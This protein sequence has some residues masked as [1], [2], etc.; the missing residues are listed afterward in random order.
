MEIF[1]SIIIGAGQAG[2]AM[3]AGLRMR[4][5][6]HVVLERGRVAQRWRTERWDSFRLLSPNWQTRLPGHHYRDGD[7]DGF[8]TGRQVIALLERYAASAPVRTGVNVSGVTCADRGYQVVTTAG[9]LWCRNVVVATG[10][11][12]RPRIPAISAEL[13]AEVVQLHSSDYRNPAQLPPGAVLVVGAGPSGQQIADELARAGRDVHIAAGRHHM[14]P[15]RYRGQ[16]SYWWM[17]RMGTLSRTVE[18]LSDPDERFALNA[19]LAGGTA[20][21]DLHRLVRAGVRPHG[22]LIGYA[23]TSLIFAA[24]LAQTLTDAEAAAARFR[25]SVDHYVHRTGADA[26]VD[27]AVPPAATWLH[28]EA[29]SLDVRAEKLGAVIWATG[30]TTDRSWLPKT[31]LSASGELRQTRGVSA[32]PGL[33]FLGLKW[34][35]RRSSHTI[36]GVGRDAEYLAEHIVTRFAQRAAQTGTE[37][38]IQRE[39]ALHRTVRRAGPTVPTRESV[40]HGCVTTHVV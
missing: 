31:A 10:D 29:L 5:I 7:P 2:L 22:R 24:D 15:R 28:R 33:Y 3:S 1:D 20:D 35:H 11:L 30:F 38:P 21:L 12:D 19:V 40:N 27:S 26:P 34:Q 37:R 25:A 18:S 13:P 9:D 8:M 16:D 14:L 23:G 32:L 4:G 6:R 36:D 39:L 17:D